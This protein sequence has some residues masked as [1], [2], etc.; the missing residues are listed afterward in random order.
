MEHPLSCQPKNYKRNSR[1]FEKTFEG[2]F[3]KNE[4]NRSKDWVVTSLFPDFN[5]NQ[6]S[7]SRDR[8]PHPVEGNFLC[9]TYPSSL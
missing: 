3:K 1:F 5:G 4:S 8:V 6:V 7:L 2:C 9:P